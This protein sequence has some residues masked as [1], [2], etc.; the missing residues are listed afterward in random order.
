MRLGDARALLAQARSSAAG[1][2]QPLVDRARELLRRTEAVRPDAVTTLRVD[3]APL[4][5]G[6]T[7]GDA[8]LTQ[9]LAHIDALIAFARSPSG[10]VDP[11]IADAR[12]RDVLAARQIASAPSLATVLQRGVDAV[13]TRVLVGLQE[14]GIDPGAVGRIAVAGLAVAIVLVLAAIFGPGLRER[15]RAEAVFPAGGAS[16]SPDPAHHLGLADAARAARRDRDALH[17]LYLYALTSLAAAEAIRYDPALTDHELLLRADGIPQ[18]GALRE[19][20]A[21]HERAWFG[22]RDPSPA[23][24]DRARAL[25]LRVAA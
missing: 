23:D 10:T 6:I 7:T 4:A 25:A 12:L 2:R 5:D 8:Q 3:D 18:V 9:A 21:L 20:V 24:A 19:L 17:E 14:L 15:V 1:A 22:L 16:R 11:A 13:V